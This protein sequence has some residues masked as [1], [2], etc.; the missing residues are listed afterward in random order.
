MQRDIMIESPDEGVAE[1]FTLFAPSVE[2]LLDRVE[3]LTDAVEN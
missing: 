3:R 2:G 1:E